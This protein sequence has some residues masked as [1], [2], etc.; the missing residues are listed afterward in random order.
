M[1]PLRLMFFLIV[2]I[3][4]LTFVGIAE[5][6]GDISGLFEKSGRLSMQVIAIAGLIVVW[7]K[8]EKIEKKRDLE[9]QSREKEWKARDQ[10][11]QIAIEKVTDDLH[12]TLQHHDDFAKLVQEER[13]M[14]AIEIEE[15]KAANEAN[16]QSVINTQRDWQAIL[17]DMNRDS[18]Q[19]ISANTDV[20]RALIRAIRCKSLPEVS[21]R[22]ES[23]NEEE[24][25]LM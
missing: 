24:L 14:H 17:R 5:I 13:R 2:D 7:K 22:D 10:N 20:G 1:I 16:F 8:L 9:W 12:K 18:M 23:E 4:V 21:G 6:A 15:F 25:Q 3:S 11:L 19:A